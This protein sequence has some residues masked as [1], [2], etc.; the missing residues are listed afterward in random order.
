MKPREWL[1]WI[2]LILLPLAI[3]FAM[4][5]AL[6]L[7]D[8]MAMHFSLDGAPDRWGSKFELLIVG[9]IMSGANLLMAL[10]YWK[11]EALF[12]MG[13]VNGI[14][15]VRGARIVLWA[16]GA[17]I[18]ALTVGASIFLVSTALAAA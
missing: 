9:G 6:P 11:I 16:M 15:T 7:P 5:A 4:L 3:D 10:I 17:L 12:A 13:L 1:G 14:K 2:A 8:T 18:V